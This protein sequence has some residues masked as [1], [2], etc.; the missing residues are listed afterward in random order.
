MQKQCHEGLGNLAL[1]PLFYHLVPLFYHCTFHRYRPAGFP[2][3]NF[4]VHQCHKVLYWEFR[5]SAPTSSL[6]C[7]FHRYR[8]AGFP[9]YNFQL[10]QCHRVLYWEFS[11]GAPTLVLIILSIGRAVGFPNHISKFSIV[12]KDV[13]QIQLWCP[14]S[15]PNCYNCGQSSSFLKLQFPSTPVS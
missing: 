9:I 3:Y 2:I 7:T 6:D 10:H 15:S 14:Y 5:S 1:V 13:N 12:M 8:P 4:Q 11:P